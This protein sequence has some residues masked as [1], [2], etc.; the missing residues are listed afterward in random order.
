MKA[1][2]WVR[3]MF[4]DKARLPAAVALRKL[5]DD[6]LAGYAEFLSSLPDAPLYWLNSRCLLLNQ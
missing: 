6:V 2:G 1:P 3:E 5:D 4:L